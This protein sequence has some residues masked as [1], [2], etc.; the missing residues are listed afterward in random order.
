MKVKT[1]NKNN[2]NYFCL[3]CFKW[4]VRKF[5]YSRKWSKE[6]KFHGKTE[7]RKS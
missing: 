7:K 6:G 3:I 4:K 5:M 2:A 1:L